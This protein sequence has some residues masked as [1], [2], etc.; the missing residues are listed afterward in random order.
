MIHL[1]KHYIKLNSNPNQENTG[2]L[3]LGISQNNPKNILNNI[4]KSGS[5]WC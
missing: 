5:E 2:K 3:L 4:K 1:S